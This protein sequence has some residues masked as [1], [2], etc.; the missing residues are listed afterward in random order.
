MSVVLWP[1]LRPLPE[2]KAENWTQSSLK[3]ALAAVDKDE[4]RGILST[5][6]ARAQR[7]EIAAK[8]VAV[9]SEAPDI[10]AEPQDIPATRQNRTGFILAALC[11]VV[12]P[13]LLFGGYVGL[14]TPDPVL[15]ERQ[16]VQKTIANQRPN[17]SLDEAINALETRLIETPNDPKAWTALGDLKIRNED[18]IG[19]EAAFVRASELPIDNKV[20]GARL[21]LLLAMTRRTQG[22]ELSDP[23]VVEPLQKSLELDPSSPAAVLLGRIQ[24]EASGQ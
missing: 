19:A 3:A 24:E 21:W 8:A 11:L 10:S 23:L 17:I 12:A 16:A 13:A 4:A 18:Y 22:R 15:A 5:A 2:L 20:D 14:G 7:A 6:Q 1:F 9:L